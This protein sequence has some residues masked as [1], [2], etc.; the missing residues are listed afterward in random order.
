MS[1][2]RISY[3]EFFRDALKDVP[4]TGPQIPLSE[5]DKPQHIEDWCELLASL[6]AQ[7]DAQRRKEGQR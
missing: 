2:E 5:H 1:A 7:R 6:I 3:A 4:A